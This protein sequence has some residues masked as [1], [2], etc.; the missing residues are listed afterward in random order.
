MVVR[1]ET[2]FQ[3]SKYLVV[4]GSRLQELESWLVKLLIMQLKPDFFDKAL[5]QTNKGQFS[6]EALATVCN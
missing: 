5:A 2:Q 6:W 3:Q 4:C 1:N